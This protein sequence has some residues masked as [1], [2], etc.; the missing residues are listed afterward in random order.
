MEAA[1]ESYSLNKYVVSLKYK[2]RKRVVLWDVSETFLTE[3]LLQA[4]KNFCDLVIESS[5]HGC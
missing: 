4:Q 5:G 1:S 3:V 2:E